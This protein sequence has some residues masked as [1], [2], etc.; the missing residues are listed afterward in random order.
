[1]LPAN[2]GNID[3]RLCLNLWAVVQYVSKYAT[4]AP[5]GSRRIA[6]VLSDAVDDVCRYVPKEQ[7]FLRRSIQR[8]FARTLGERDYHVY[9]AVHVGLGLPLVVPLMPV[10]TLNTSGARALKSRDVLKDAPPD[11]PVHYDSK[12]DKFDN[13]L[14]IFRRQYA[15][16]LGKFSK[17]VE[18]KVKYVS[19]YEFR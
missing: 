10:V 3:W 18:E 1:M 14:Q 11:T 7:D 9:E 13:R 6:E 8:F 2:L 19:L 12:L 16:D 4:K 5:K 17:E 15:S